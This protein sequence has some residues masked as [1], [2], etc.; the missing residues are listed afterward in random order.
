MA[1]SAGLTG[2]PDESGSKCRDRGLARAGNARGRRGIIP[3]GL[4]LLLFQKDNALARWYWRSTETARGT[5]KSMI[6]A[7]AGKLLI[8]LWQFATTG[9]PPEGMALRGAS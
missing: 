3:A 2:S 9:A 8:V 1:R 6:V 5:R 4:A 7:L